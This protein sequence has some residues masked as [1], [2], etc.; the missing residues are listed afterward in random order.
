MKLKIRILN[1][2]RINNKKN[3]YIKICLKKM[4]PVKKQQGLKEFHIRFLNGIILLTWTRTRD[5]NDNDI[6][7][8]LKLLYSL[9]TQD[10]GT[11]SVPSLNVCWHN[12][13]G[14]DC[15]WRWFCVYLNACSVIQASKFQK[16]CS[17]HL[18]V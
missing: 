15:W 9:Y 2:Y 14:H 3:S 4:R 12:Y 7:S 17:V 8:T 11:A 13:D 6:V 18:E 10:W 5:I 16:V 1:C